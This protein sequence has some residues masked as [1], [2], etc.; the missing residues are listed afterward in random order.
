[1]SPL[2][3]RKH[4]AMARAMSEGK[5]QRQAALDAG[6]SPRSVKC[7]S[8]K[9]GSRPDIQARVASLRLEDAR[10]HNEATERAVSAL[11]I[12]RA[13]VLKEL[14][15]NALQAK[16]AVPVLD[17][18]GNPTGKYNA[19][20]NAS[21]KALELFGKE[22]HRMFVDRK[23]VGKP[24]QFSDLTDEELDAKRQALKA[25]LD[26]QRGASYGDEPNRKKPGASR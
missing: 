20:W 11:A 12:T 22:A 15:D 5:S 18:D 25:I 10:K 2:A 6:Y 8:S 3:N 4:E 13:D 17:K 23:E 21:N 7:T 1:M 26:A 19:N 14:W 16:A 9:V 24:G